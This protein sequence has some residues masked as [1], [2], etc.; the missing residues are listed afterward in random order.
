ML[1]FK[2]LILVQWLYQWL[3]ELGI[4]T[5]IDRDCYGVSYL[6]CLTIIFNC[7]LLTLKMQIR[8][9]L[10]NYL[11]SRN[12]VTVVI[13]DECPG[14]YDDTTFFFVFLIWVGQHLMHWEDHSMLISSAISTKPRL[15]IEMYLKAIYLKIRWY[16][17]YGWI[18]F[19]LFIYIPYWHDRLSAISIY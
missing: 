6:I 4:G 2:V 19:L 16:L 11:C 5:V 8:C 10:D 9:T 18:D 12:P 13:A 3:S 15:N 14:C 7:F 1:D 17:L